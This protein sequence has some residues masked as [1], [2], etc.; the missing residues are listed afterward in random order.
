MTTWYIVW[1]YFQW[2]CHL[3]QLTLE[4]SMQLFEFHWNSIEETTKA[5]IYHHIWIWIMELSFNILFKY[6][7][8]TQS[9]GQQ[10]YQELCRYVI[11]RLQPSKTLFGSPWKFIKETAMVII[12]CYIYGW[13]DYLSES[14]YKLY[15]LHNDKPLKMLLNYWLCSQY[16][17]K[18]NI[19]WKF[20]HQYTYTMIHECLYCFLDWISLKIKQFCTWL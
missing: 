9:I 3:L 1:W 4:P 5:I 15:C 19:E 20:H 2:L 6:V 7:S 14:H 13:W 10:H 8:E 11:L 16:T 18:W 17:F 12:C